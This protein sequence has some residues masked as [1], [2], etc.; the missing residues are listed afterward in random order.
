MAFG[1][2]GRSKEDFYED[3][4][5]NRSDD[6]DWNDFQI[7]TQINSNKR[8]EV[9]SVIDDD[10]DG[11]DAQLET[12]AGPAPRITIRYNDAGSLESVIDCIYIKNLKENNEIYI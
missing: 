12:P 10:A 9:E 5:S 3:Y 4:S 1:Y 6:L 8:D 2:S 11:S 7:R